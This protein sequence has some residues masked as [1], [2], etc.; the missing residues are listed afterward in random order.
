M[1]AHREI[2]VDLRTIGHEQIIAQVKGMASL[3]EIVNRTLDR[4]EIIPF[5]G[6]FDEYAADLREALSAVERG[7]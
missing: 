5:G 6:D 7:S 3:V 1:A 4:H 2:T